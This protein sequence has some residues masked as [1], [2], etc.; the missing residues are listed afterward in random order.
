LRTWLCSKPDRKDGNA[1]LVWLPVLENDSIEAA[2]GMRVRFADDGRAWHFW[3]DG[4]RV[5]QAYHRVLQFDQRQRRHRVAWDIFLLYRAG[6]TWG[7][8]PP[9]PDFWMHQLFLDDVPKLEIE[10]LRRELE[11]MIN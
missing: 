10:T 2:A 4:L 6:V 1:P 11:Q 8:T 5:S 9:V 3:D 7:K